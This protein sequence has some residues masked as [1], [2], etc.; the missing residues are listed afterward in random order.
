MKPID[1]QHMLEQPEQQQSKFEEQR[2]ALKDK[3][4]V[5]SQGNRA[6][7]QLFFSV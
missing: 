6:M 7:P 3:K 4:A 1:I 2:E 5:L